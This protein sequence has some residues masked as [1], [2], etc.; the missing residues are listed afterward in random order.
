M[1]PTFCDGLSERSSGPVCARCSTFRAVCIMNERQAGSAS[2]MARE[3]SAPSS[4]ERENIF[5][6]VRAREMETH[7]PLERQRGEEGKKGREKK[8][9]ERGKR[10]RRKERDERREEHATA[11]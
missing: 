3:W 2:H 10:W 1:T 8:K 5:V 6:C 7:S 11:D 9:D 4:R